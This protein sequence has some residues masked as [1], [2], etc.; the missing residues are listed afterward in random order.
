MPW[1]RG[2][3]YSQ[4]LRDRVFAA[5]D[6]GKAVGQIA[7]ALQVSVSYVSKAL[8]RRERTGVTTALPQ[9]GHVA[10]K[11][12]GL[13]ADIRAR[14]AAKPD[15]TISEL[16]AWLRTERQVLVSGGV[17]WSTLAKLKLTL[18]KSRCGLPSRTGLRSPRR[19]TGGATGS[20]S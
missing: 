16:R 13:H 8:S 20:P 5:A 1:R 7:A 11:L 10:P 15:A 14:V 4:D 2:K 6:A 18:K 9:H 17:V 19:V 3:A 12:A